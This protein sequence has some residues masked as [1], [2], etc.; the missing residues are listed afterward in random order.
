ATG[1]RLRLARDAHDTLGLGL[2]TIA[3]KSDLATALLASDP[4]RA[5]HEVVQ[6]SHLSA[7]VSSDAHA[8]SVGEVAL[9]LRGELASA[10]ATLSTAGIA[11][12]VTADTDLLPP[13]LATTLAAVLREAVTNVLRH[14]RAR[15][16]EI[17]LTDDATG[18]R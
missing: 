3:M 18:I 7:I 6:I 17:E 11:V 1:E 13:P 9:D 2:S 12:R 10:R 4:A 14:S 16:C 15:S 5:R 8:V